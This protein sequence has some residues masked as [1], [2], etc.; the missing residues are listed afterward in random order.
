MRWIPI[1][2]RGFVDLDK[3]VRVDFEGQGTRVTL[4]ATGAHGPVLVGQV[5]DPTV[6]R[7]LEAM[8]HRELEEFVIEHRR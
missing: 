4:F 5:S 6:I 7:A 2:K 3:V 1:D 8:F